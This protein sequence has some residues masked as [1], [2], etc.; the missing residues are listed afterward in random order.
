ME[1]NIQKQRLKG[2]E[3][4]GLAKKAPSWERY[5]KQGFTG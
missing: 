2:E 4:I 1:S 3:E 5:R